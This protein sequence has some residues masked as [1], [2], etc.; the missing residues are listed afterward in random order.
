MPEENQS[1]EAQSLAQV[2]LFRRLTADELEQ[3]AEAWDQVW[4]KA[5]EKI[6]SEI[7]RSKTPDFRSGDP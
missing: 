7:R 3:L 2:N 5:G 1:E 6:F 4:Y